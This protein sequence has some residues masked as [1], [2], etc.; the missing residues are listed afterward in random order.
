MPGE[1]YTFTI[2][3]MSKSDQYTQA[4]GHSSDFE[5]IATPIEPQP[6]PQNWNDDC[7][8]IVPSYPGYGHIPNVTWNLNYGF[9]PYNVDTKFVQ[10]GKWTQVRIQILSA[11]NA[12]LWLSK[13]HDVAGITEYSNVFLYTPD[14]ANFVRG[15]E[16][17][18][19]VQ[20]HASDDITTAFVSF[21]IIS[22]DDVMLPPVPNYPATSKT[23]AW[24]S[25]G[26][27]VDP[28]EPVIVTQDWPTNGISSSAVIV[29][30]SPGKEDSYQVFN[31]D[32][33]PQ[34]TVSLYYDT[35]YWVVQFYEAPGRQGP[36]YETSFLLLN[37]VILPKVSDSVDY[38]DSLIVGAPD[39]VVWSYKSSHSTDPL[40]FANSIDLE[41]VL[42]SFVTKCDLTFV[43]SE[44][45]TI[46]AGATIIAANRNMNESSDYWDP[47]HKY[48]HGFRIEN[49]TRNNITIPPEID[50]H[51]KTEYYAAPAKC[52][53]VTFNCEDDYYVPSVPMSAFTTTV[54][55]FP[56]APQ[57]Q[58]VAQNFQAVNA[59]VVLLYPYSRTGT[60]GGFSAVYQSVFKVVLLQTEFM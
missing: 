53:R 10:V 37:P 24:L 1:T 12:D 42:P 21:P 43:K 31:L 41:W 33:Q 38:P 7:E 8:I 11:E 6:V 54:H 15:R 44:T 27:P 18:I 25:P 51:L 56:L 13:L 34:S 5:V 2:S 36:D 40:P 14:S 57:I 46:F 19:R 48:L 50:C 29:F 20:G 22:F 3:S 39:E 16:Y 30:W 49:L 17:R 59:Q 55:T 4:L 47:G 28:V 32:N 52:D 58:S 35:F 9:G 23:F 26:D 45:N 60:T